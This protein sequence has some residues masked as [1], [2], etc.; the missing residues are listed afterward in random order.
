M[1]VTTGQLIV[2]TSRDSLVGAIND[3]NDRVTNAIYNQV[4]YN[5]S[6]YPYF[7]G[8]VTYGTTGASSVEAFV[9]PIA[10]PSGQLAAVDT[11]PT[12]SI[13]DTIITASTL[14]N[15]MLSITK[16]L[17]KIRGFTANWYHRTDSTDNLKQTINSVGFFNLSW[18]AVPTGTLT[19]ATATSNWTRTGTLNPTLSPATQITSGATATAATMNNTIQNCYNAWKTNCLDSRVIYD[20]YTCHQNC[21]SSCHSSRGRR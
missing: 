10:I 12:W 9:N 2:K 11:R 1:T 15:N 6:T 19:A 20:F 16:T 3:F 8:S 4:A 13:G 18:P 21:H 17:I 7:S 5:S 14:W